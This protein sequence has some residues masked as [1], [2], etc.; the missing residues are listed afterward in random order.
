MLA[1]GFGRDTTSSGAGGLWEPYKLGETPPEL[2]NRWSS[3]T[4]DFLLKAARG[5]RNDDDGGGDDGGGGD[6]GGNDEDE[7]GRSD[8]AG[9]IE[10]EVFQYWTSPARED[11][12]W[13]AV[14]PGFR[15]L[16]RAE[17]DLAARVAGSGAA[18]NR[19]RRKEKKTAAAAAGANVNVAL[20]P[21][22][23][24]DGWTFH[25]AAAQPSRYLPWLA[26]RAEE[27]GVKLERKELRSL[28]ELLALTV[29]DDGGDDGD[30]GDD[31]GDE[32]EKKK[33]KNFRRPLF[34]VVVNCAGLEGGSLSGD[35]A[36][37]PQ[38]VRGQV[39]RLLYP[40][41]DHAAGSS[42][43]SSCSWEEEWRR[44]TTKRDDDGNDDD[45]EKEEEG[46][47]ENAADAAAA[48]AA[49]LSLFLDEETYLIKNVDFVVAGGTGQV[50]D[51][52]AAPRRE[53]RESILA[54]VSLLSPSLVAENLS[55]AAEEEEEEEGGRGGSGT[56]IE[57]WAGLRPLR[58]PVRLDSRVV[59]RG[60][61][62]SSSNDGDD[63]D[64]DGGGDKHKIL[65][66]NNYGHGGSG[67]TLHWGCARD[68]VELVLE[69]LK[70]I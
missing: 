42:S 25:S 21:P 14:A 61:S 46:E 6:G 20:E 16:T 19:Q 36:T 12:P 66:V 13:S 47:K 35:D 10:G 32:K 58:S 51:A 3:E 15:R 70:E 17:L 4:L 68:A 5:N 48:A 67:F 38:P 8:A 31:D 59:E 41:R 43:S 62:N 64:D 60:S 63:D 54:R 22:P 53:D 2:V 26:R 69:G 28:D 1:K 27:R 29:A 56:T 11:P 23:L 34:D 30:D 37:P 45:G 65:V 40:P 39:A 33:K 44:T 9:V 49:A 55:R 50:G 18:R 24:V 57:D 7:G 52:D